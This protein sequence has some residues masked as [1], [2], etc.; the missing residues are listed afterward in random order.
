MIEER[1]R[2]MMNK[3]IAQKIIIHILG[4]SIMIIVLSI[5]LYLKPLNK[6][7]DLLNDSISL[8]V[9]VIVFD[10]SSEM[11]ALLS[12]MF[13][14]IL[15]YHVSSASMFPNSFSPEIHGAVNKLKSDFKKNRYKITLSIIVLLLIPILIEQIVL[16]L[17]LSYIFSIYLV[18]I[19][20]KKFKELRNWLNLITFFSIFF[21]T[22]VYFSFFTSVTF[23]LIPL[24][25]LFIL[26]LIKAAIFILR[27]F[28]Y[29]LIAEYNA[30]KNEKQFVI[31]D[32][33]LSKVLNDY[34]YMEKVVIEQQFREHIFER[35]YKLQYKSEFEKFIIRLDLHKDTKEKVIKSYD[36]MV[37]DRIEVA[38][39]I[40]N[41]IIRRNYTNL[42][43]AVSLIIIIFLL[44]LIFVYLGFSNK[45]FVSIMRMNIMILIIFRLLLRSIEIAIAFF[46]DIKSLDELKNSDISSQKR[47]NLAIYSLIEVI[48][49]SNVFYA[50]QTINDICCTSVLNLITLFYGNL[51]YSIAVSLFNVS[52][53]DKILSF[54]SIALNQ[55]VH[56]LQIILSV[57]LLSISITNY[58]SKSHKRTMYCI[59]KI[60][61]TYTVKEKMIKEG[62]EKT[63]ISSDSLKG[64][65]IEID[66]KWENS[67][68]DSSRYEEINQLITKY[69]RERDN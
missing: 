4:I 49:L 10:L 14:F 21:S 2:R 40:G 55:F 59:S 27:N 9:N 67:E 41:T 34:A 23:L 8:D 7:N 52:Y 63:V 31:N 18:W 60:D 66:S 6:L 19:T 36:K 53:P 25:H 22:Y 16:L 24:Y 33:I 68:I 13:I 51:K 15:Y 29:L 37:V 50:L 17:C 11:L 28:K 46:Q 65:K 32:H 1:K 5:Q 39:G 45:E 58:G 12:L 48:L 47:I 61:G 56:I 38:K 20:I 64:L 26:S 42:F 44:E 62:I 35:P 3:L 43:I 69:L 30:A 57:I 54:N